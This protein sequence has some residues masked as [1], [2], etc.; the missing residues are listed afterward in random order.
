MRPDF[1]SIRS[2]LLSRF[3]G[4]VPSRRADDSASDEAIGYALYLFLRTSVADLDVTVDGWSVFR[5]AEERPTSIRGVGIMTLLPAGELPVEVSLS[6]ESDGTHYHVQTAEADEGW[7]ALSES[8]RWKAV[9]WY[10]TEGRP[11][12]WT[13]CEPLSGRDPAS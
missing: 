8:K 13:W 2:L 7:A 10:A 3:P 1:E 6:M 4:A 12:P 5:V 11:P 9:Y